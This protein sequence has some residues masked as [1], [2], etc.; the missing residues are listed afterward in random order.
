MWITLSYLQIHHICLS[1][2]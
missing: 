1:F 2:V